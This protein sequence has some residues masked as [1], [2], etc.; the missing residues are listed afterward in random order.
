VGGCA[1]DNEVL[2]AQAGSAGARRQ[3]LGMRRAG[4]DGEIRSVEEVRSLQVGDKVCSFFCF[5]SGGQAAAVV[6]GTVGVGSP[7]VQLLRLRN[8]NV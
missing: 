6:G 5:A 1:C 2:E 7:A 3:G 8:D 4:G